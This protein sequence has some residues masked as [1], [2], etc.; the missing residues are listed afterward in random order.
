MP[1]FVFDLQVCL[2]AVLARKR[3]MQLWFRD[4]EWWMSQS[5]CSVTG[6]EEMEM[7]KD[8]PERLRRDIKCYLCLELIKQVPLFHGMDDMI[9]DNI[10]DRLWPLVFSS[11]EKVIREGDPVPRMV[12]A[13]PALKHTARYY[14]SN[15]RTWAAVNIQLAWR[16]RWSWPRRGAAAGRRLRHYAAMFMSLRPHDH[17]E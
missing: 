2:H 17:L 16:R 5:N 6:D 8:L 14:S 15:W 11:G 10:G 9:L 13:G 7:I 4:M 12:F 3:K 1:Q